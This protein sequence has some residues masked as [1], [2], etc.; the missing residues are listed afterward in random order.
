M[1]ALAATS[2]SHVAVGCGSGAVLTELGISDSPVLYATHL[3][4]IQNFYNSEV[5]GE[6][7]D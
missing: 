6:G 1:L 2:H 4:L 7:D 5:G 3:L